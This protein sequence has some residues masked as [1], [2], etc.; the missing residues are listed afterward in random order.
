M[1]RDG[2]CDSGDVSS[3]EGGAGT[4]VVLKKSVSVHLS[5]Q[6]AQVAR[7][8][9]KLSDLFSVNLVAQTSQNTTSGVVVPSQ[10]YH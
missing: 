2:S 8:R 1:E 3:Q 7:L 5:S 9:E 10:P 4:T 6:R